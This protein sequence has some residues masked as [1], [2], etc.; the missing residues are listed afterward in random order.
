MI[1][2]Q[3]LKK[4]TFLCAIQE[5]KSEKSQVSRALESSDNSQNVKFKSSQSGVFKF[6]N[7]H[8]CV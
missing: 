6:I 8:S 1:S 3:R 4:Q 5:K 7:R 2:D